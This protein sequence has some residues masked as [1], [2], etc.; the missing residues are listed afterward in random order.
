MWIEYVIHHQFTLYRNV[1]NTAVTVIDI[2]P[3][4]T[5][6]S[7]FPAPG[8]PLVCLAVSGSAID[9]QTIS[10]STEVGSY[11]LNCTLDADLSPR[12]DCIYYM[13]YFCDS[14]LL[15]QG[16]TYVFDCKSKVDAAFK[17]MNIYFKTWRYYCGR[18]AWEYDPSF[19]PEI[20]DCPGA[21]NSLL[22]NSAITS[23]VIDSANK[24]LWNNPYLQS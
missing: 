1:D 22:E 18:W 24:Y 6:P 16:S 15:A 21:I 11:R 10:L 14:T 9:D 7:V 4:S 5:I 23:E 13:A 2:C 20:I 17:E 3:I 12:K 19:T 8:A